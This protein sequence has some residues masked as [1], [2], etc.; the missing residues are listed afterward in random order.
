MLLGNTDR[1]FFLL[2]RFA[3]RFFLS[4]HGFAE[5]S[6]LPLLCE[7]LFPLRFAC[8]ILFIPFLFADPVFDGVLKFLPV[9]A[10]LYKTEEPCDLETAPPEKLCNGAD[11]CSYR[12]NQN[13]PDF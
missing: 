10:F 3:E 11:N 4:L 12:K 8:G 6:F 13:G 2:L 9:K 7:L 5:F 1:F